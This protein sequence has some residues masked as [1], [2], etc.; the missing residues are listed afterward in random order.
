MAEDNGVADRIEVMHIDLEDAVLPQ[1]VDVLISEWMGGLGVDENMLAPLVMARDRWLV[2]GGKIIPASVT[3]WL[4]PAFVADYSDGIRFWR[5]HPHDLELGAIAELT[6]NESFMTQSAI[7][8]EDLFAPA[9][10]MWTHDAFTCTLDEADRSFTTDLT[11]T[12]TRAGE[13]SALVTWFTAD[14]GDGSTLTNAV[15]EPDTHWGRLLM[16][17]DRPINVRVGSV[18]HAQVACDPSAM[19]SCELHWLVTI[20][21][22]PTEEHDTRR[23]R[24]SK[25]DQF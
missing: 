20:D 12:T 23:G 9:Q 15:G 4:A 17:L 11:F 24:R 18:V 1:K 5:S 21:N 25:R 8:V 22:G 10:A 2:P 14:M 19:G 16:P 13:I 6:A 3:A 7:A